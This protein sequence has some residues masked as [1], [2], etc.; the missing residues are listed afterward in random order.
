MNVTQPPQAVQAALLCLLIVPCIQP[1]HASDW[2]EANGLLDLLPGG[3][4]DN[5]GLLKTLRLSLGGWLNAGVSY[6]AHAP[7][8][9]YNGPVTFADRSGELQLNQF[10]WHLQ[11][12]VDVGGGAWDWGGRVDFMFGTDA[13]FTEAGGDPE[14]HWDINLTGDRFYHIALPQAYAE[15]FVPVGTGLRIKVGHFYTIVGGEAIV[16]P[17]NF[18]YSRSYV[19][20][21]GEP[22][23]HSGVLLNYSFAD[24]LNVNAGAVTGSRSGGWDGAFDRSHNNT[25]FLGGFTWTS[26][27]G[28]TSLSVNATHG[29]VAS[30][31]PADLNLV[32]A[33]AQ[34]DLRD[35]LHWKL[36]H[37]YGWL[38]ATRNEAKAEW[39]GLVNYLTWD[40]VETMAAGVRFEWFRDDDGTR[41]FAPI[42][43][44]QALSVASNYFALT[45]GLT[46]K[47]VP[48]LTVRPNLRYDWSD[49]AQAFN[50]RG[51][52]NQVLF[53]G[54][55]IILF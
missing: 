39:Y 31:D 32:S 38:A 43:E 8:D 41:V 10:Y 36:Q 5:R 45:L 19:T 27:S 55:V 18:F 22:F 14:S 33:V 9:R 47:P 35:N 6:N 1:L 52:C 49:N 11:R 21:Y 3:R 4:P 29:S 50:D 16:A 42:R 51:A 13:G 15:A 54:D 26:E 34:F 7:D 2:R 17:D 48:W 20:Q 40:V 23:T 12:D 44:A 24:R 28:D 46:W 25:G 37:D 30:N 53:S